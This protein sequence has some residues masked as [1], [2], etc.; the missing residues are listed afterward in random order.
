[1]K[2]L[3]YCTAVF[4]VKRTSKLLH[5]LNIGF[6][7]SRYIFVYINQFLKV[8]GHI[9]ASHRKIIQLYKNLLREGKKFK[10]YNY[11]E[12]AVRRTRDAFKEHK[13]E[14]DPKKIASLLKSAEENLDIV[15]RQVLVGEMYGD[16]K[17]IIEST[18]NHAT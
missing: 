4:Y 12:Y 14:Q 5:E 17:L 1:M 3:R 7:K 16:G 2:C 10:S 18:T 13:N 15:R 11:R 8:K 9:M 6:I